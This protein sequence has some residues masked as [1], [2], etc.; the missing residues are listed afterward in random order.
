MPTFD[1]AEDFLAE[2]IGSLP[3]DII[4]GLNGG[5]IL[6]PDTILDKDGL[7]VLGLYHVQPMGLGRYITIHFGSLTK[8]YG[9]LSKRG[10]EKK[11]R[12]V[13]YHELTHHLENQAGDHSLEIQDAIDKAHYLS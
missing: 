2:T 7:I 3:P 9:H 13:L 4:K 11:L 6:L 5:V 1:E 8:A 10:F 12:E